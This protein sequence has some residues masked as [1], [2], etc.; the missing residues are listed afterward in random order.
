VPTPS[1]QWESARKNIDRNGYYAAERLDSGKRVD[2]RRRN[3]ARKL[4]FFAQ[5]KQ[6]ICILAT[7]HHYQHDVPRIGFARTVRELIDLWKPDFI[8]EEWSDRIEELSYAHLIADVL[9]IKWDNI[10]LRTEERPY[11]PDSNSLGV[12]TQQDLTF[13]NE[14]EWLWL[15]RTARRMRESALIICGFGHA[16]SLGNKFAQVGFEVDVNVFFDKI[17]DDAIKANKAD[18]PKFVQAFGSPTS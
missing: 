7:H 18:I 9:K 11:F 13:T 5:M 12:G 16:F 6:C 17:D 1:Y 3:K 10:D 2:N 14:R 15:V 4:L 8:G